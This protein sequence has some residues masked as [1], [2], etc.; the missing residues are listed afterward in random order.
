MNK[1]AVLVGI[2]IF[3]GLI[4][5]QAESQVRAVA[6][7]DIAARNG[8]SSGSTR[9]LEHALKVAGMPYVVTTDPNTA[10]G[11][12]VIVTSSYVAS[13]TFSKAERT[14]LSGYVGSGGVLVS[15]KMKASG[16][17]PVFGI[18]GGTSKTD[19][20][21]MTWAVGSGD[22]TLHWF[23]DPNERTISLGKK[24][25]IIFSS[26]SYAL[27]GASPLA[28][29]DDG[30]VAVTKSR[31]GSGYA[32]ALGFSYTDL[33][34]R[35][36]LDRDYSA[37]RSYSNGFE[38]T[39]D[40]VILF[41]RAVYESHIPTAVFKHTSPGESRAFLIMTHDVDSTSAMNL[42]N[43]FADMEH[44]RGISASYNITTHYFRD[45]LTRDYYTPGIGK[46]MN[47]LAGNHR[48][49]S[50]SVGHF[51]D[52]I[53]ETIIPEGTPGN[54]RETYLPCYDCVNKRTV[55]ATVYGELEVSRQ[56]LDRDTGAAVVAFRAGHLYF[57]DKQFNVMD[58]LGY[59]YDSSWS[60]NDVLTNFP[61]SG[62]YNRSYSGT[63][64]RVYE[65]PMTISDGTITVDNYHQIVAGW[66]DIINRNAANSAPTVLLIHPNRAFKVIAEEEL[67]NIIPEGIAVGSLEDFGDYWRRRDS[68]RFTTSLIGNALTIAIA[69][70]A[71]PL[72]GRVSLV[73]RD[74]QLV[75]RIFVRKMDSGEPL[76]FA[77]EPRGARDLIIYQIGQ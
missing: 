49:G 25:T 65:I 58:A 56:I 61:F 3:L 22:P 60:A 32:Y 5:A 36:Q 14:L 9:S 23:D 63:I 16:L 76:S 62:L 74:G 44:E 53:N 6:L 31:Y 66:L 50:H 39:S 51:P 34:L 27:T 13:G 75:G 15:A 42:M 40:T 12:G 10:V 20:C 57:N 72:D 71:V 67:L 55:D 4:T 47:L 26:Q 35:N 29:F 1:L 46:I 7:L 59:L 68:L 37:E 30:S 28:F 41:L 48:V 8:E 73:I 54:T 77:S 24:G 2:A 38:P 43:D 19:R 69:D 45:C 52:W 33:I 17:Y 64:S 21:S 11:Y 70:N 18:S